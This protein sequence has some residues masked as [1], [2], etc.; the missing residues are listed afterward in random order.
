[1]KLKR[2]L[3]SVL[4]LLMLT[5][6]A[7]FAACKSEQEAVL[8]EISYLS[9]LPE[10]VYVNETLD[11]SSLKINAVYDDETSKEIVYD[12]QSFTVTVDTS[13]INSSA[14]VVIT[15]GGKECKTTINVIEK[16]PV[17]AELVSISYVSGMPESVFVGETPDYSSLKINAVYDDDTNRDILYNANTF[18]VT[19]NTTVANS[20]AE[21]VIVYGEKECK[22]SISVVEPVKLD[23]ISYLSGLPDF[24][25]VDETPDY[26]SLKIKANYDN[27]TSEEIEYNAQSFTVAVDTSKV[28]PYA[29]MSITY[30][31]KQCKTSISVVQYD[32][33]AVTLP[34]FATTFNGISAESSK[35]VRFMDKTQGYIVG[36]ANPFVFSPV[37]TYL[38]ESGDNDFDLN[39]ASKVA[40]NAD[41][42]F[43]QNDEEVAIANPSDYYTLNG[44][45]AAF[46]FTSAAADKTF[47]IRVYPQSLNSY[48][49]E[50]ELEEYT[51][52]FKFTVKDKYYNV[53]NA[54]DLLVFDNRKEVNAEDE[55]GA[56]IYNFRAEKG[57]D[58]NAITG[59]EGIALHNNI[60]LSDSDFPKEY[61]WQESELG[62]LSTEQKNRIKGSLK[63]YTYMLYRNLGQN[64]KFA[65]EG[66]YFAIE[67]SAISKVIIQGADDPDIKTDEVVAHSKL[68]YVLGQSNHDETNYTEEM[69][70]NN[71]SFIGNLNRSESK[72]S[73][74]LIC[75]EANAAKTHIYNN[76]ANSW[77]ITT[78]SSTNSTGHGV[79]VEKSI[80]EDDYNCIFYVSGGILDVKESI[81]RRAGGPV[82]IADHVDNEPDEAAKNGRTNGKGGWIPVLTFDKY[83]SDNMYSHVTG[84]E[85]WFKQM[86]AS[87]TADLIKN[88][89]LDVINQMSKSSGYSYTNKVTEN[90][91]ERTLMNIIAIFK[92]SGSESFS[93]LCA[94]SSSGNATLGTHTFDYENT[95]V[96]TALN[97]DTISTDGVPLF[98]GKSPET[99][100]GLGTNAGSVLYFALK[101]SKMEQVNYVY[102]LP[103]FTAAQGEGFGDFLNVFYRPDGKAGA[104]GLIFGD[105][106]NSES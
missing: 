86:G 30:G 33:F 28:N 38:S 55:E 106:S 25:F 88:T 39:K 97:D 16:S 70:F 96:K 34:D 63:D 73:G 11:Y 90:G 29:E 95:N 21:V 52:S 6:M 53:Y 17:T 46:T 2:I 67:A 48:Q 69:S 12:A 23:S 58:N 7:F 71:V 98:Y 14:E 105:F 60:S 72:Y 77:Y 31:G 66:N 62:G 37:I 27:N 19:V 42:Y 93:S 43:Y 85:S 91:S 83:T 101:D 89:L 54:V 87:E 15:Y 75:L 100:T 32:I 44:E 18:T 45:A 22:T 104:L 81:V 47:L 65:V 64:G 59:L 76:I 50:E 94:Y 84:A 41:V 51:V 99:I 8:V 36:N 4:S 61:F 57:L 102:E 1:M 35:N 56:P 40:I 68:F 49:I 80:Y 24:L 26:S 82:V 9:G 92:D 13:V 79:T 103:I 20:A 78:F 3:I 10:S 74:G 5:S